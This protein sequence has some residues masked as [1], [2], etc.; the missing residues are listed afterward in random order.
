MVGK[1]SCFRERSQFP[2]RSHVN[3]EEAVREISLLDPT[4]GVAGGHI[5]LV[6]EVV[7][8]HLLALSRASLSQKKSGNYFSRYPGGGGHFRS[9]YE[10]QSVFVYPFGTPMKRHW[11]VLCEENALDNR[12]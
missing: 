7:P 1:I 10:D 8:V 3:I 9:A 5:R 12:L 11:E 4:G 2:F 6:G